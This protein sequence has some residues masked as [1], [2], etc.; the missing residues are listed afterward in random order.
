MF[1]YRCLARDYS[2]CYGVRE[3]L[4]GI[5]R[6]VIAV[7]LFIWMFFGRSSEGNRLATADVGVSLC[8]LESSG[9]WIFACD[10]AFSV[11][12][13]RLAPYS[14]FNLTFQHSS[15][16]CSLAL[17]LVILAILCYIV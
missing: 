8:K 12:T 6:W 3:L 7:G 2:P 5:A 17:I 1:K 16:Y 15:G 13:V 14:A 4:T 10:L 11:V 9:L